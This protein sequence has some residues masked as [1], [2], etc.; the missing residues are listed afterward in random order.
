VRAGSLDQATEQKGQAGQGTLISSNP[1]DNYRIM[2]AYPVPTDR[3]QIIFR[4]RWSATA[5]R[6]DGPGAPTPSPRA[7]RDVDGGRGA[8][9][10]RQGRRDRRLLTRLPL[11]TDFFKVIEDDLLDD[12][13]LGIDS[14]RW[15][16]SILRQLPLRASQ[17]ELRRLVT[18]NREWYIDQL[19][20]LDTPN[21]P[22][23]ATA[24]AKADATIAGL[25]TG[26]REPV[27]RRAA[28]SGE[29]VR[30]VGVPLR[31]MVAYLFGEVAK[32]FWMIRHPEQ[33]IACI[34]ASQRGD[35]CVE[36]DPARLPDREAMQRE[37][38]WDAVAT[39][40]SGWTLVEWLWRDAL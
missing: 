40:P 11:A 15:I 1:R 26:W 14:R 36:I 38:E 31:A 20:R 27:M 6:G 9:D 28:P 39:G 22:D 4:T 7:R 8:E 5:R 12:G 19:L 23:A 17:E 21:R 16:C 18:A 35:C 32:C 25:F 37:H 29:V 10:D 33:W 30:E 34:A 2:G 24:P 3:F 13:A